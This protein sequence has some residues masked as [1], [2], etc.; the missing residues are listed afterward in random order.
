MFSFDLQENGSY[1]IHLLD[2]SKLEVN[3]DDT[4]HL[5][6]E[7]A[8]L[9]LRIEAREFAVTHKNYIP[10]WWNRK[11][12]LSPTQIH[13]IATAYEHIFPE[14][15]EWVILDAYQTDVDKDIAS[16]EREVLHHKTLIDELKKELDEHKTTK[17]S[18]KS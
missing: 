11:S 9:S 7:L 10:G 3:A 17:K 5:R 18:A 16:L 13:E 8:K 2:G 14:R 4:P 6:R 1:L 15:E 12:M